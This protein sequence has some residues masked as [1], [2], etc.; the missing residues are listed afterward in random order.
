MDHAFD[1]EIVIKTTIEKIFDIHISLILCI[2]SKF[3]YDCLV[4]LRTI[5]EKKLMIDIMNFR[6]FY[7]RREIT[8]VR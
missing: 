3:L 4:R 2:D 1:I 7:K 5:N 6:K 8:K